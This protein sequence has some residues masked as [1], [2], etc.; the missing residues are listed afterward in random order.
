MPEAPD[1]VSTHM[2]RTTRENC[3]AGANRARPFPSGPPGLGK[4]PRRSLSAMYPSPCFGHNMIT[5]IIT[6]AIKKNNPAQT[7]DREKK[8][9]QPPEP[10]TQAPEGRMGR[11]RC[12]ATRGLRPSRT[13]GRNGAGAVEARFR[14]GRNPGRLGG[15]ECCRAKA[16]A[17]FCPRRTRGPRNRRWRNTRASGGR[18]TGRRCGRGRAIRRAAGSFPRP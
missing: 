18:N 15:D 8:L 10:R 1:A 16:A 6:W 9:P 12:R 3:T 4:P 7:T 14:P 17:G 2:A 13:A 11:V 5:M